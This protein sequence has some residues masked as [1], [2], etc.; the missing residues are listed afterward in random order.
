[1]KNLTL[2][3]LYDISSKYDVEIVVQV[4]VWSLKLGDVIFWE[5]KWRK[6]LSR[7]SS[8][9]MKDN[10]RINLEA[11]F[12]SFDEGREFFI[13]DRARLLKRVSPEN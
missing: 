1:M 8:Y 7:A 12:Y 2:S 5:S 10:V 11:D 3:Q 13:P 6:V 9:R 4:P